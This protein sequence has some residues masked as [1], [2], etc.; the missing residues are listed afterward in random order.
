[1]ATNKK[2]TPKGPPYKAAIVTI[3]TPQ[4]EYTSSEIPFDNEDNVRMVQDFLEGLYTHLQ[5][6]L[7]ISPDE[8]LVLPT[9]VIAKSVMKIR[10]IS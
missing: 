3:V 10:Y 7:P 2:K 9:D 8:I 6:K 1:M 5:I 4:G